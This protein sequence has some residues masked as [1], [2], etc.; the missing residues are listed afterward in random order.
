MCPVTS[1]QLRK[2]AA[3]FSLVELMIAIVAGII[4]TGAAITFTVTSIK[5]NSDYVSSTRL[6][7]ELRNVNDYVGAEL[8][9]AGYDESA[10]DYVAN[11]TSTAVSVFAPIS[12]DATVGQNCIKYAYDRTGGTRGAINLGTGEVRAIRRQ[13][14]NIGGVTVGVIEVGESSAGT[15]PLCGA[16]GPDYSLYPVTCNTTTGWCP[17][18]DP[19]ILNVQTFTIG[20]VASGTNSNGIQTIAA[21]SGFNAMRLREYLV[22]VTGSLRSDSLISRT[23]RSNIK[24]RADCLRANVAG[25]DASP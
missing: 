7:Q 14:A 8:K 4:V 22:T 21:G 25:C 5:A 16:A 19:R 12:V 3:G 10:M 20:T 9:R 11:P 17:F 13:T 2:F 1:C 24:V 15:S 18:S 23:V 6:L